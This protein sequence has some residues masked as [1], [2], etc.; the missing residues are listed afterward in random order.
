MISNVAVMGF[1]FDFRVSMAKLY[2]TDMHLLSGG[3]E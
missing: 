2:H 3:A 1:E